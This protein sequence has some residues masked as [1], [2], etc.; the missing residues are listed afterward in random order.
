V[1]EPTEPRDI[2][3]TR[4]SRRWRQLLSRWS[5]PRNSNGSSSVV[6]ETGRRS[7]QNPSMQPAP[8]V[9]AIP[10]PRP[11]GPFRP[12]ILA[13]IAAGGALRTPAHSLTAKSVPTSQGSFPW[14][15][16]WINLSGSLALGLLLAFVLER[17]PPSRFV[18]P[19][20]AVGF[21]GAYT[22]FSTFGVETTLLISAGHVVIAF[23]YVLGS[24]A[25]G[26]ATVYLGISVGRF[27][28]G[29]ER[30]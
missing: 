21:L 7:A 12:E 25:G 11:G 20:A 6:P 28:S 9:L 8:H 10:R 17:W 19:F 29:G 15:T 1:T 5:R 26:L 24:L 16:F 27:C 3:M 18:R 4:P 14:G 23:T 22:T 30:R 2:A 13:A